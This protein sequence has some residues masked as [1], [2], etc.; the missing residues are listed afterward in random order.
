MAAAALRYD[1]E[2][3][4]GVVDSQMPWDL[5]PFVPEDLI[6]LDLEHHPPVAS[7]PPDPQIAPIP[8]EAIDPELIKKRRAEAAAA[9]AA[10][11]DRAV[12]VPI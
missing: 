2:V 4:G 6:V 8:E 7:G 10:L 3:D 12:Y 1:I 11:T 9:A 5:E